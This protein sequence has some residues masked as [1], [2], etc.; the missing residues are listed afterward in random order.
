MAVAVGDTVSAPEVGSGPV[1]L[2]DA[3]HAVAFGEAHVSV[4]LPPT[5][6]AVGLAEMFTA[7]GAW[8]TAGRNTAATVTYESEK[9]ALKRAAE[10][11]ADEIAA[12]SNVARAE[13]QFHICATWENPAPEAGAASPLLSPLVF[14]DTAVNSAGV[15][16][17]PTAM[18]PEVTPLLPAPRAS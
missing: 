7:G 13:P 5:M 1:Q 9:S 12:V 17:A 6:I 15:W 10:L 18:L 2:P 4:L 14:M 16:P 8:G 11:P 3:V